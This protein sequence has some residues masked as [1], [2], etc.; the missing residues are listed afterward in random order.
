MQQ[1]SVP[2]ELVGSIHLCFPDVPARDMAVAASGHADWKAEQGRPLCLSSTQ[3][4][5]AEIW[6]L[7]GGLSPEQRAATAVTFIPATNALGDFL[8]YFNVNT[9]ELLHVRCEQMLRTAG[10]AVE[11]VF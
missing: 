7:T 2:G 9:V 6:R 5:L 1:A 3:I 11:T 10:R 8:A 4:A